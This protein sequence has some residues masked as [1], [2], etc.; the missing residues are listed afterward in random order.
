MLS[1]IDVTNVYFEGFEEDELCKPGFNKD[2]K[3]GPPQIVIGLLVNTDGYPLD[4]EIFEG[5]KFEV[6]TM[7]PT[8]KSFIK[9]YDLKTLIVIADAGLMS[10]KNI[11]ELN[12]NDIKF[13][14]GARIKNETDVVQTK[15]LQLKLSEGVISEIQKDT[16]QRLVVGYSDARAKNDLFNRT[17]GFNKLKEKVKAGKLTKDNINNKGYNKYLKLN[18]EVKIEIDEVKFNEDKK[19]D[20]LKDYLTNTKLSKAEIVAYHTQLWQVEK[21]FRISKSD[22][23][24]RPIYHFKK[25][26]I[27]ALICIIF[28]SYKLYKELERQLKIKK[29]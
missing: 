27:K 8:I 3:H 21:A 2:G 25:E 17:K 14:I 5:N 29:L 4:Y 13:I 9:K 19:W 7:I 20:G 1:C 16:V 26:R 24:I 23:L 15:I 10:N 22:L 11:N 18:G 28:A 6:H 12:T